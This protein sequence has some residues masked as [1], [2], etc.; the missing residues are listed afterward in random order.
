MVIVQPVSDGL[1]FIHFQEAVLVS[2]ELL[3]M[4]PDNS[5]NLRLLQLPILIFVAAEHL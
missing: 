2:V 5:D 4:R 1:E 3:E